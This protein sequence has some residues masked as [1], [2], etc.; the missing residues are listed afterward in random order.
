MRVIEGAGRSPEEIA[1]L[2]ARRRL[3]R[4]VVDGW[5]AVTG[6][7]CVPIE[8]LARAP[9]ERALLFVPRLARGVILEGDRIASLYF[10]AELT[11]AEVEIAQAID[12]ERSVLE[13]ARA[14]GA[15]TRDVLVLVAGL[16]RLEM[17]ELSHPVVW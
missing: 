11:A 17:L 10:V 7:A 9:R 6:G 4:G 14:A 3:R 15:L 8:D 16:G 5:S 12:D 13:L 1:V 2:V